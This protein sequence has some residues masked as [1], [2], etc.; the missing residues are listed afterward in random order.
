MALT[1]VGTTHKAELLDYA[2]QVLE[3]HKDGLRLKENGSRFN[4]IT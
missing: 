2:D 3:F 1:C 4:I